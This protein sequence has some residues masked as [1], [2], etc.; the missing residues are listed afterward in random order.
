MDTASV[1]SQVLPV[2][3]GAELKDQIP[4]INQHLV[5][6][7]S[8]LNEFRDFCKERANIE[9]DYAHR[10]EAL[11]RKYQSKREKKSAQTQN[12]NG[13]LASPLEPDFDLGD[14]SSTYRAWSAILND[15]E[16]LCKDRFAFSEALITKVYD[17][18]KV[19]GT[20]KDDARKR[21]IQF[22]Q[23]LLAERD[24]SSLELDKAK[25]RYDTSCEEVESSKQKQERAYDERNQEKL[26]KSYYQDILDMNNNKN[27][28]VLALHAFNT[29]RAKYFE[30]DLPELSNN[31]QALDESRIEG[32]KQIWLDYIGLEASLTK[33]SEAH[34]DSMVNASRSIDPSVDSAVFVR[35]QRKPWSNPPDLA[36]QSSPTFNDT[37][38]LVVDD[39]ARVFLTN[40]LMK[41][42][43]KHWQTTTEVTT[44]QKDLEAL[45]STRDAC[46]SSGNYGELEEVQEN[47]LV[48]SRDITLLQT[49]VALLD[50]EINTIVQTMGDNEIQNRP[51]DFKAASFTIP[52]SCDYCQSTIWG[53]AKQGF[54]CRDCGYNCHSKCEM[55]VPPTC[56]NVKGGAK[57]QRN[58]TVLS[59][60]TSLTSATSLPPEYAPA[61]TPISELSKRP[62]KTESTRTGGSS[63]VQGS[64]SNLSVNQVQ[65][66][67]IYDYQAMGPAELTVN[68][69]DVVTVLEGDDGSGWV[70]CEL[71]GSKSG[72]IP[73]SYIEI[74]QFFEAPSESLSAQKVRALYDYDAQSNLELTIRQGDVIALTSMDCSEGWWE[75][76]LRGVTAQFPASYVEMI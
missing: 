1:Y 24:K 71:R 64:E 66:H 42:R 62:S 32:L 47:I 48:L 14:G 6:G 3:F 51:H 44:R 5:N 37:E 18:L 67:V 74:E 53:I 63:G 11:V 27:S 9:R 31:M 43:R 30:Q 36:F 20:K 34:L 21:H 75:G 45:H 61:A 4:T 72:L 33:D 59:S 73:G 46:L 28:Y 49:T 12:N 58:S 39:N 60:P 23:R 65:A 8:F 10:T 7:I 41:L 17:P 76:T 16:A 15:T 69:G 19:L 68:T 70:L 2:S 40:K 57:L 54:T 50:A 22:A 13:S 25:Q 35:T 29:H 52:T 38:E 55:K 56:S 26:K